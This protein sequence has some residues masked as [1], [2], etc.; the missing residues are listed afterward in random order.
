MAAHL[1]IRDAELWFEIEINIGHTRIA[2]LVGKNNF[3]NV[4]DKR[5]GG[6]IKAE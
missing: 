5:D 6:L 3:C 2:R 4:Q 1:R